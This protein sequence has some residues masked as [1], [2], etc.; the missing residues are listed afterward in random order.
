MYTRFVKIRSFVIALTFTL[1]ACLGGNCGDQFLSRQVLRDIKWYP[2]C[3]G[4]FLLT[5]EIL[6]DK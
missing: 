1:E 4:F 3:F 6:N 2:R 5:I